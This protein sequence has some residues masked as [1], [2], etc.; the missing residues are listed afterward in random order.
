MS[1]NLN[2]CSV[3][4]FLVCYKC[5]SGFG[6]GCSVLL[7]IFS[8]S[9]LLV[10]LV[11][12]CIYLVI[13]SCPYA[14]E[15]K[16]RLYR[17]WHHKQNRLRKTWKHLASICSS[18]IHFRAPIS[19]VKQNMIYNLYLVGAILLKEKKNSLMKH[20]L[21]VIIKLSRKSQNIWQFTSTTASLK[22]RYLYFMHFSNELYCWTQTQK[23]RSVSQRWNVFAALSAV[24]HCRYLQTSR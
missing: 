11:N 4:S 23:S 6:G 16:V 14:K 2:S 10:T 13:V 19:H 22:F 21:Y 7:R 17:K 1:W 12:N 15:F 18:V 3:S 8:L 24:N 5:D 20:W 9:L